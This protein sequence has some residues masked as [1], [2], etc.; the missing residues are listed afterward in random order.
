MPK[1]KAVRE[2]VARASHAGRRPAE[3][4]RAPT[5]LLAESSAG[6]VQRLIP[7]RVGRMSESPVA[8]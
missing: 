5:A 4:R 2:A 1:G 6:R 8:F 7:T 3:S